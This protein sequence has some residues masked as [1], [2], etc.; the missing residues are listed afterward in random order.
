MF[1]ILLLVS[2]ILLNLAVVFY[3]GAKILQ[4]IFPFPVGDL[5][6]GPLV[7]NGS[8]ICW[9]IVLAAVAGAYTMYG[10]MSSMAYTAVFQFLMIFAAG[11]AIFYLG[12]NSVTKWFGRT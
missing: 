10:G 12:Y 11:F 7:V 2:Y 8:L 4:V 3:G 6:L 9:L 5:H 1:A